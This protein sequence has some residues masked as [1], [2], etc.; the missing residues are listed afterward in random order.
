MLLHETTET[1]DK[2]EFIDEIQDFT[3]LDIKNKFLTLVESDNVIDNVIVDNHKVV[4][5]RNECHIYPLHCEDI[6]GNI[7]IDSIQHEFINHTKD[8]VILAMPI[9][10]ESKTKLYDDLHEYIKTNI[11]LDGVKHCHA[12]DHLIRTNEKLTEFNKNIFFSNHHAASFAHELC[13][14]FQQIYHYYMLL[15]FIPDLVL[16]LHYRT[17]FTNH[18]LKILNI[19]NVIVMSNN[20][21]FINHGTT[22]F[23]GHW[24]SNMSKNII[25]NFFYNKIIKET[26]LTFNNTDEPVKPKKL[27]LLR[28]PENI[29]TGH[30]IKNRDEVIDLCKKYGYVEIDQ[31]ILSVVDTIK[32]INNSTHIV[33]DSGSSVMHLLW[34]NPTIKSII[35][36]YSHIYFNTCAFNCEYADKFTKLV[37]NNCFCDIT[38]SRNSRFIYNDRQYISN[39]LQIDSS[40]TDNKLNEPVLLELENAVLEFE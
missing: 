28:K 19:D 18:L 13:Y 38:R 25:K 1:T 27:I 35:I 2:V 17:A 9:D 11:Y 32:L 36:D 39:S 8:Y 20:E 23:A 3:D 30:F 7:F 15:K 5:T 40:K 22:Y 10:F 21:K 33:Q 29:V 6:N 14:G 4:K 24:K 37:S 34:S 16:I 12:I 31:T 26:L